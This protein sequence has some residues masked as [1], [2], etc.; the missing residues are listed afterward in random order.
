MAALSIALSLIVPKRESASQAQGDGASDLVV[1]AG[2]RDGQLGG[3]LGGDVRGHLGQARDGVTTDD[4]QQLEP[5]QGAE[6]VLAGG[7]CR[8]SGRLTPS[9]SAS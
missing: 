2:D 8:G 3:Q 1:D 7:P 5:D 6:P 4:R 9:S